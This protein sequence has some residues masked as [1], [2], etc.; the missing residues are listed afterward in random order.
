MTSINIAVPRIAEEFDLVEGKDRGFTVLILTLTSFRILFVFRLTHRLSHLNFTYCKTL[1]F[2]EYLCNRLG[3]GIRIY[4]PLSSFSHP[5]NNND[6]PNTILLI[7]ILGVLTTHTMYRLSILAR[8]RLHPH[9]W[10]LPP[11]R[12]RPL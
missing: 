7:P 11:P 4:L 3:S 10:R 6:I 12:R 1:T 9:V 5:L 8:L 2:L